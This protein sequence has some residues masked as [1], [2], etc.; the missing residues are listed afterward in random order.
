[1]K[2]TFL[3]IGFL[4]LFG[5]SIAAAEPRSCC[6]KELQAVRPASGQIALPNHVYVDERRQSR[7]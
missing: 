2:T 1:M 4:I 6:S 7:S 5:A 3:K